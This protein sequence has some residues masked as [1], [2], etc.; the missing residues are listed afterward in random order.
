VKIL[1]FIVS[2]HTSEEGIFVQRAGI[3]LLNSL[4]CQ[5]DGHQKL[6]V[7]KLGAMEKMLELI[8]ERV[9]SGKGVRI[10]SWF[11]IL[12]LQFLICNS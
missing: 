9:I 3:C 5:I 8:R 10:N 12:D 4:A 7:G 1:L 6:L 11:A 2:E